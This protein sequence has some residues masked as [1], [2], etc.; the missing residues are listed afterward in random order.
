MENR[1]KIGFG[2]PQGGILTV[3]GVTIVDFEI[4]MRMNLP[5]FDSN[6]SNGHGRPFDLFKPFDYAPP[7]PKRNSKAELKNGLTAKNSCD[8][9]KLSLGFFEGFP[10]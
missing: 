10:A 6:D 3:G 2:I 8:S 9:Y 7:N 1:I 4:F 5:S